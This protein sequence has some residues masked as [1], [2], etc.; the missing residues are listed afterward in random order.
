[1]RRPLLVLLL[2]LP[3]AAAPGA[4]AAERVTTL[5]GRV[6]QLELDG[7]GRG[8]LRSGDAVLPVAADGTLGEP[9]RFAEAGSL[10]VAVSEAGAVAIAARGAE[11]AVLLGRGTTEA[12]PQV[13][14]EHVPADRAADPDALDVAVGDDGRILLAWTEF[15]L[16]GGATVEAARQAPG[17]SGPRVETLAQLAAGPVSF[18]APDVELDTGAAPIVSWFETSPS[19]GGEHHIRRAA[20]P[21]AP[22]GAAY[23]GLAVGRSKFTGGTLQLHEGTGRTSAFADSDF[24]GGVAAFR[25]EEGRE[26][27]KTLVARGSDIA[28]TAAVGRNGAAAVAWIRDGRLR[29]RRRSEDGTWSR[30]T[31]ALGGARPPAPAL[32]VSRLGRTAVAFRRGGRFVLAAARAGGPFGRARTI[33]GS[34]GCGRVALASAPSGRAVAV[35]RCDGTTRLV[36]LRRP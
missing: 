21:D 13:L 22:F 30:Q 35:L 26:P 4:V 34:R 32:A 23:R 28:W 14:E 12:L 29:V 8:V 24:D 10:R 31:D 15:D 18:T 11:G 2:A 36:P 20:A 7:A 5:D 16:E 6:A 25:F 1:M 19:G 27:E 3:A 17:E 33:P 9:V